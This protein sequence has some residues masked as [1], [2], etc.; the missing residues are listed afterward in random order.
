ML[1][2]A[3]MYGGSMEAG[4]E[5]AGCLRS[6]RPAAALVVR[7]EPVPEIQ[8]EA[9]V[10]ELRAALAREVRQDGLHR[11]LLGTPLSN[12]S[13][14]RKPAAIFS[15]SRRFS[16]SDGKTLTRKSRLAIGWP[17]SSE[18]CHAA[19]IEQVVLVQ[20]GDR[21]GVVRIQVVLGDLVDP[22]ANHL[23]K[24]LPPCL[25]ADGFG[26][27]ADR[28]LGFDEAERHRVLPVLD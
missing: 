18:A 22:R 2:R 1:D 9:L 23:A 26:D 25:A 15:A 27:D 13:S 11:L 21:L 8:L 12:A 6:A 16:P 14:P 20:V 24:Q 7:A 3:S 5:P 10:R 4:F 17:T 19:S 28:V